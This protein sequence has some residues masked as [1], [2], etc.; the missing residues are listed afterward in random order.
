MERPECIVE[1]IGLPEDMSGKRAYFGFE[2]SGRLHRGIL[3]PVQALKWCHDQGANTLVWVAD[4]HATL[5]G[6]ELHDWSAL[7]SYVTDWA[8]TLTQSW[9]LSG[10]TSQKWL[11]AFL[12]LSMVAGV[13]RTLRSIDCA[14]REV[15]D[16]NLDGVKM[17][18][19]NYALLQAVD[20]HCLDID[21]AIGGIDQRK[22][23]MMV[24]DL[25]PKL[26]WKVPAVI[27]TSILLD[28]KGNKMSKSHPD[29]CEWL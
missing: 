6:K 12:Q 15:A 19:L 3:H 26:G 20:I 23:H 29:T 27:H 21:I 24:R 4:K 14:G 2:P 5:N 7:R 16:D 1:T 28:R 9:W 13:K 10:G 11:D 18:A 8:G 25:F 17:A 22:V